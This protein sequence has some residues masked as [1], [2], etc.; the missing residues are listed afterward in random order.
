MAYK[1]T[2]SDGSVLEKCI[3][4][5]IYYLNPPGDSVNL[6]RST[7]RNSMIISGMIDIDEKTEGLYKWAL[8]SG[9]NKE[10]YKDI[11]VEQFRAG[12]LVRK[13]RFS[14]AF[15][16][17]YS[18]NYSNSEG[19]GHFTIYIR[20]FVG[21][22]IECT[23]QVVANAVQS[24]PDGGSIHEEAV[25]EQGQVEAVNSTIV[26]AKTGSLKMSFIDRIAKS[27]EL[28]DNSNIIAVK[29]G[30][31]FTKKDR[32][33]VLKPNI[34]YT[35]PE[36]YTYKTDE[37]GRITSC[38]GVLELGAG[39]RKAHAQRTVGGID[40]KEDDDGG[41]LIASIFK[42]SGDFDNLVPMN[43]NLNKGEWR[44]LENSWSSALNAKPPKD[45][46]VKIT[47][48]YEGNSQR[49]ASF[50][51]EQT[52]NNKKLRPKFFKNTPGGI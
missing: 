34:T 6:S 43:G 49:P 30:E 11:T 24:K 3:D 10:C 44:K 48:I 52:I 25:K 12:Q 35:T 42:G 40:R 37:L 47:P 19:V 15:V 5:V 4:N 7:V 2:I 27:K 20:Q 16:V 36:G 39:K 50:K 13:V 31:Q 29:Y 38:E 26:P 8:I 18:E 21:M 45:V 22:D 33:K 9:N 28:Q 41:H 14:K 23:T 17:D 46:K 51:I 1:V 32:K